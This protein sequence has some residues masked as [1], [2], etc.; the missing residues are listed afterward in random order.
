MIAARK[1]VG[2]RTA[3]SWPSVTPSHEDM[4][5]IIPA[6]AAL[7]GLDET[8]TLAAITVADRALSGCASPPSLNPRQHGKCN[9]G[10]INL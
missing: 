1:K 10:D 6:V 7:I 4:N 9:I 8:A 2:T 5:A 3:I